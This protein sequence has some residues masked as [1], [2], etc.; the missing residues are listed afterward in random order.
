[1]GFRGVGNRD[2]TAW[3][4]P[5]RKARTG[6]RQEWRLGLTWGITSRENGPDVFLN[7]PPPLHGVGRPRGKRRPP[8]Q[9]PC[10][11]SAQRGGRFPVG[12]VGHGLPVGGHF[13]S[14][15]RGKLA[16]PCPNQRHVRAGTP[17]RE[18]GHR[19]TCESGPVPL[20]RPPR[21]YRRPSS[22]GGRGVSPGKGARTFAADGTW[23]LVGAIFRSA[24]LC[25]ATGRSSAK[26]GLGS[27]IVGHQRASPT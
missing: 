16:C 26:L 5:D 18:K 14:I 23:P 12:R 19:A 15:M 24:P 6:D 20:L 27:P 13:V 3:E 4:R 7:C 21:P 10:G 17:R 22:I 1:M 11:L 25:A 2:F 8:I 9:R